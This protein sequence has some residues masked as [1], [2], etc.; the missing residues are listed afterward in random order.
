M[1]RI[2]QKKFEEKS[3]YLLKQRLRYNAELITLT[4]HVIIL[5]YLILYYYIYWWKSCRWGIT[6]GISPSRG[7]WQEAMLEH[8]NVLGLKAIKIG[9]YTYST[10][11]YFLHVKNMV[12]QSH[13]CQLFQQYGDIKSQTCN[14]IVC[15]IWDFYAKN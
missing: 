8:I 2:A 11:K 7:L 12:W 15:R 5:T 1:R 14:D 4:I 13:S 10:N 9:I 3:N 6:D